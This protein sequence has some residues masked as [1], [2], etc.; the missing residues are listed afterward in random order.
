MIPL[1]AMMGVR[2]EKI[3]QLN[4]MIKE[5]NANEDTPNILLLQQIDALALDIFRRAAHSRQFDDVGEHFVA[6]YKQDH[7]QHVLRA[8]LNTKEANRSNKLMFVFLSPQEDT[9]EVSLR[10]WEHDTKDF[11]K[12]KSNIISFFSSASAS[13]SASVNK[14]GDVF[15]QIDI[16]LSKLDAVQSNTNGP[17]DWKTIYSHLDLLQAKLLHILNDELYQ[18]KPKITKT[19][20]QLLAS[21]ND[22]MRNVVNMNEDIKKKLEQHSSTLGLFDPNE[23]ATDQTIYDFA[24]LVIKAPTMQDRRMPFGDY[25]FEYLGGNNNKNWIMRHRETGDVRIL[26]VEKAHEYPYP[27]LAIHKLRHNPSFVSYVAHDD[28]FLPVDNILSDSNDPQSGVRF[29]FA[30]T[31]FCSRG[32]LLSNRRRMPAE[33]PADDVAYTVLKQVTKV[34]EFMSLLHRYSMAYV[35]IKAENFMLRDNDEVITSDFKS[36]SLNSSGNLVKN[37]ISTTCEPPEFTSGYGSD[38]LAMEPFMVYQIGVM[39]YMLMLKPNNEEEKKAIYRNIAERKVPNYDY[40]VF[41]TPL[42]NLVQEIINNTTRSEPTERWSLDDLRARLGMVDHIRDVA[43]HLPEAVQ[44]QGVEAVQEQVT[45][46]AQEP[47]ESSGIAP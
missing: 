14:R 36:I 21:T 43:V 38:K 16:I 47:G 13:A 30:V 40:P 26:R 22:Y 10:Q 45:E 37:D 42:G 25:T 6:W 17:P 27:Y 12:K 29:N 3:E 41:Q 24:K 39:L 8:Q 19:F 32:D 5:Y 15:A 35:D 31:E 20:I 4:A 23:K 34:A 28:F 44:G 33:L 9:H 2:N 11:R 18:G 7:V 46:A 1:I